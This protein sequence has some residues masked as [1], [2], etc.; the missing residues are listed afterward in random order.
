MP[1]EIY[2]NI[3]VSG[4]LTGLVYGLMALG[5][6]VIFGVVRVVNFAHG[7]MMT[8]A[9]YLAIVLFAAFKLDPLVMMMPIAG[10]LFVFG[11]AL[12]AGL[13][14][15]FINRPE[16]SQFM[17][18]VA[19]AIIIVNVLL[20]LFGPDARSVQT[21]YSFDSFLVGALIVDATKVYA[22]AAAIVVAS[23]LF[24]FFR[25]A[26]IGKAIRACADNYTG[27]LV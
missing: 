23:A 12:Q 13:I 1:A 11:S 27:A 10:V 8:I 5:L 26:R 20:M 15:P 2:L 6:S 22:G 19:L 21:A 14:N 7:E 16:H 9:M 24:A 18:L 4:L 17:L 3:A 25:F